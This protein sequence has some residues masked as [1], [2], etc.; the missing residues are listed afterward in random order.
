MSLVAAAMYVV[1]VPVIQQ[2]HW[3]TSADLCFSLGNRHVR[4]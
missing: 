2:V 4:E 1:L 3:V